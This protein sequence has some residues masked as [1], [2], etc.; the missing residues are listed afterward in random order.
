[1]WFKTLC[2]FKT[3]DSPFYEKNCDAFAISVGFAFFSIGF[4]IFC[5][6]LYVV[7][8]FFSKTCKTPKTAENRDTIKTKVVELGIIFPMHPF[9]LKKKR[10]KIFDPIAEILGG[11][12]LT[13]PPSRMGRFRPPKPNRVDAQKT[14]AFESDYLEKRLQINSLDGIMIGA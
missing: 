14:Y 7:K 5:F 1:M 11:V 9:K 10:K 12:K 2:D 13:P 8:D 6:A 3:Y 4:Q